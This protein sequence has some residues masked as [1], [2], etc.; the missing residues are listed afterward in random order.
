MKPNFMEEPLLVL[1]LWHSC[2]FMGRSA[3]RRSSY[4]LYV[5]RGDC[6]NAKRLNVFGEAGEVGKSAYEDEAEV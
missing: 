6:D 5:S 4:M 1:F 2:P 3:D